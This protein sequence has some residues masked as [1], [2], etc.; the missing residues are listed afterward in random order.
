M[1]RKDYEA[2]AQAIRAQV[3]QWPHK[4][5]HWHMANAMAE[6]IADVLQKDNRAFNRRL[7]L[8]ACGLF[9]DE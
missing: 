9:P 4:G 6:A 1:S 2:I 8:A 7:F 5:T 3:F